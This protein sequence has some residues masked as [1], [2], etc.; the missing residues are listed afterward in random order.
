MFKM[1]SKTA[2]C[3]LVG[4]LILDGAF[5]MPLT[6]RDV[7][8]SPKVYQLQPVKGYSGGVQNV[9]VNQQPAMQIRPEGRLNC[10]F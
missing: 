5:M 7:A 6:I 3:L 4:I 8:G 9:G 2:L 1:N 10:D